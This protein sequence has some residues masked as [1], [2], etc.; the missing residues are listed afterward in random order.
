MKKQHR[1]VHPWLWMLT[2]TVSLAVLAWAVL[3]RTDPTPD[4][5]APMFDPGVR[6]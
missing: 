2:A 3:N 4:Q 1:S 5:P 6:P